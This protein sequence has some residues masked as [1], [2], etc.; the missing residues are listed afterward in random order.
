MGVESIFNAA[1]VPVVCIIS[2]LS[3]SFPQVTANYIDWL[4]ALTANLMINFTSAEV[5][6]F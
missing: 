4:I 3:S 6:P 2:C 5:F 1:E